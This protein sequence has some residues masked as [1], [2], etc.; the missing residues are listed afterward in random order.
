[1]S[2]RVVRCTGDHHDDVDDFVRVRYDISL[3]T[4]EM[5][6][7]LSLSLPSLL[8]KSALFPFP[9]RADFRA[10]SCPSLFSSLSRPNISGLLRRIVAEPELPRSSPT[11]PSGAD[12]TD[13][14][15][16]DLT[17]SDRPRDR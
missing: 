8:G 3:L 6:L 14:P 5:F 9:N 16:R 17:L 2:L 11:P 13:D 7:N 1:M 15:E 4:Y 12:E 10:Y